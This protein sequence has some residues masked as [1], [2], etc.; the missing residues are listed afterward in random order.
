MA[1]MDPL[2]RE[3]MND[4]DQHNLSKNKSGPERAQRVHTTPMKRATR[5][6]AICNVFRSVSWIRDGELRRH[7]E[8]S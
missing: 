8:F 6:L 7:E 1:R 3:D 4:P 5:T 2:K